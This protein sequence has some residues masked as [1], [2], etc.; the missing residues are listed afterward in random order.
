M[1]RGQILH[2]AQSATHDSVPG[3]KFG[4]PTCW[5][6]RRRDRAGWGATAPPPEAVDPDFTFTS[7]GAFAQR[8]AELTGG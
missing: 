3:G 8:H 6:D 1:G 5:I 4:L 7:M 2:T